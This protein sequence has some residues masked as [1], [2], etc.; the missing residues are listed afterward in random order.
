MLKWRANGLKNDIYL[1]G[2]IDGEE[3]AKMQVSSFAALWRIKA[4]LI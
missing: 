1:R 2:Q 3:L 4:L